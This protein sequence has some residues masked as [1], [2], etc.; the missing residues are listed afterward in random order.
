MARGN[1]PRI[2]VHGARELERAMR[3]VQDGLKDLKDLNEAIGQMV[4]DEARERVPVRTGA[5]R[6]TIRPARRARGA[7]VR[8]GS[9]KVPYAGPVH[10][11]WPAR[12]ID[13]QP[14]LYDAIDARRGEVIEAYRDRV[15]TLIREADA[16]MPK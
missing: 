3:H 8:A 15:D 13:P 7:T 14:F 16:R 2:E 9:R 10:F 11:G 6:G 5:L 12:N 1:R 4:A